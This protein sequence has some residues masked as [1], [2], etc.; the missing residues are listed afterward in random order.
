MGLNPR[1]TNKFLKYSIISFPFC[2]FNAVYQNLLNSLCLIMEYAFIYRFIPFDYNMYINIIYT[3][4]L[5]AFDLQNL[6][7]N[8]L[9]PDIYP[10]ILTAAL[11]TGFHQFHDV[12]SLVK[13][14]IA[15]QLLRK[16][17][18]KN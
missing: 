4:G 12:M 18:A 7:A 14:S 11:Q 8:L 6:L 16:A 17:S 1:S 5:M 3:I 2:F 13:G 15:G 9:L 10:G